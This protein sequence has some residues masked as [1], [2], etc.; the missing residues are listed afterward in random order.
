MRILL[1]V[2]LYLIVAVAF[3]SGAA[4]L[5]FYAFQPALKMVVA[6]PETPKVAPRLQAWLDRK[7]EGLIYAEKEKAAALAEKEQAEKLRMSI[8]STAAKA[9]MARARDDGAERERAADAK[10]RAQREARRRSRQLEQTKAQTA[11]GYAPESRWS[12]N[13]VRS[14]GPE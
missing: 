13:P 2:L 5:V 10:E 7:A 12:S 8:V 9:A 3:L 1:G 14:H 11:Y 6:Q 4:A